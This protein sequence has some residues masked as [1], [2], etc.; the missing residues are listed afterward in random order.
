MNMWCPG[1][2]S[3][4]VC[5]R[6]FYEDVWCPDFYSGMCGAD[7]LFPFGSSFSQAHIIMYKYVFSSMLCMHWFV[8][9]YNF[10]FHVV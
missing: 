7:F 2:Y 5:C 4:S 10:G 8:I 1:F 6:G 9:M 3:G